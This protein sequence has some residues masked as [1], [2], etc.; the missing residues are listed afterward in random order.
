MNLYF[1]DTKIKYA[2]QNNN[3]YAYSV[4]NVTLLKRPLKQIKKSNIFE[5]LNKKYLSVK[6]DEKTNKLRDDNHKKY[7]SLDIEF[8]KKVDKRYLNK[9]NDILN[10]YSS[11]DSYDLLRE[12]FNSAL[13]SEKIINE[14]S[15][16]ISD[17]KKEISKDLMSVIDYVD[18]KEEKINISKVLKDNSLGI[19]IT[20]KYH[21]L[22][23]FSSKIDL[24]DMNFEMQHQ[25]K[26]LIYIKELETLIREYQNSKT[27]YNNK[28]TSIMINNLYKIIGEYIFLLTDSEFCFTKEA[29]KK[30]LS[31][32]YDFIDQYLP[33]YKIILNKIWNYEIENSDGER[34]FYAIC[35]IN[36]LDN[37]IYMLN[38]YN[39]NFYSDR[40]YIC[41]IPKEFFLNSKIDKENILKIPLPYEIKERYEL[42][43]NY[44]IDNLKILKIYTKT[45]K[46]EDYESL[47]T[48]F[49][50]GD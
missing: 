40:G 31:Y 20:N 26:R 35:D 38:N 32:D 21:S 11:I 1:L 23:L 15:N 25:A 14:L 12:T 43:L 13:Q 50:G 4:I 10:L 29:I 9:S 44:N 30:I 42:Q 3:F 24:D 49:L 39:K 47:P 33:T 46:I 5:E 28:N 6:K 19:L 48:I 27:I 2:L 34:Y 41:E 37:K 17:L 45:E 22:K 16:K 18:K 36:L 7:N 8:I